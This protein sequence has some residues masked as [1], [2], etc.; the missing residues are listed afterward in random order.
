MLRRKLKQGVGMENWRRAGKIF[1]E[2][3]EKNVTKD[4]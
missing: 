4:F 2:R 3:V 1:E